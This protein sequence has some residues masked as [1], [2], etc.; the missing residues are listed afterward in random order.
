M[1][2][3]GPAEHGTAEHGTA[4]RNKA[5]VRAFFDR[6]NA[7]DVAG[8]FDLLTDDAAWFS[9][10]T[11]RFSDRDQMRASIEWVNTELL[12]AP[13]QQTVTTLTAED[14][15]VAALTEGHAV[16]VA[17]RRY[18]QAYHFLFE[19]SGERIGRLWEFNDT[20]HSRT[21]FALTETGALPR[22]DPA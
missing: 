14:D 19:F 8:A 9:L 17:G 1:T 16:T 20:Y 7:G 11:R 21:V 5:A 10:S 13:I 2:E 15:R 6:M 12:R 18:D 22:T 4:A 3:T